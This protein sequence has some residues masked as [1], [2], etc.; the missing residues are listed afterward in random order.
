MGRFL[1]YQ[2]CVCFSQCPYS[3]QQAGEDDGLLEINRK[4]AGRVILSQL[5]DNF[6]RFVPHAII[7]IFSSTIC[8]QVGLNITQIC[9]ANGCSEDEVSHSDSFVQFISLSSH[10]PRSETSLRMKRHIP[11]CCA[12]HHTHSL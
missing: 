5:C 7:R 9:L 8:P 3:I 10:P 4:I 1:C 2:V 12:K 11:G 6:P